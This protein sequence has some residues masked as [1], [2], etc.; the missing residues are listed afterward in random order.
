MVCLYLYSSMAAEVKVKLIWMG[1][2]CVHCCT[3]RN[4]STPSN[5]RTHGRISELVR[6]RKMRCQSWSKA[7]L[8]LPFRY[9]QHRKGGCGDV[10]GPRC[11]WFQVGSLSPD[12]CRPRE[13]PAAHSKAPRGKGIAWTQM[14]IVSNSSYKLS[15]HTSV[16]TPL[17]RFQ[18]LKNSHQ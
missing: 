18:R 9:G 11:R 10:S 13:L 8:F 5:L 3:S 4:V 14:R 17:S 7:K 6:V 16:F 2:I 1:D 12:W 15:F